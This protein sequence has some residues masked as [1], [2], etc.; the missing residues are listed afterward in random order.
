M[1]H[2]QQETGCFVKD[3][4]S[5][6]GNG[7]ETGK[8]N[9][10]KRIQETPTWDMSMLKTPAPVA[11]GLC[12]VPFRPI[13]HVTHHRGLWTEPMC[14]SSHITSIS[15]H[16]WNRLKVVIKVQKNLCICRLICEQFFL[17]VTHHI[18]VWTSHPVN[19]GHHASQGVN[20]RS[21]WYSI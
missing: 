11:S 1:G 7:I 19:Y 17:H 16:Y 20:N 10:K 21:K 18:E 2:P 9:K 3:G 14:N 12:T 4:F 8:I 13:V 5:L 6:H 15:E